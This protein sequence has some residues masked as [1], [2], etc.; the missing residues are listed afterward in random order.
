MPAQVMS[1]PASRRIPAPR[2]EDAGGGRGRPA[3]REP[4]PDAPAVQG[5]DR[6]PDERR[7]R[8]AG[9]DQADDR[10]ST[11]STIPSV[12]RRPRSSAPGRRRRRGREDAT[13]PCSPI[14]SRSASTDASNRPPVSRPARWTAAS[15]VRSRHETATTRPLPARRLSA[16]S[17]LSSRNRE[18][19]RS[20]SSNSAW[21]RCP[22]EGRGVIPGG[23]R[24]TG[25]PR[26]AGR[27]AREP[28]PARATRTRRSGLGRRVRHRLRACVRA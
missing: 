17:S 14:R 1:P 3:Q 20:T 5:R 27:G 28:S 13:A 15:I 22:G 11:G 2:G 4:L 16:V 10:P 7:A 18:R 6:R 12:R 26:G 23:F 9:R 24:G 8:R 25:R 21:T 19:A